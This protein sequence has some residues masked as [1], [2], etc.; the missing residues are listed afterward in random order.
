VGKVAVIT[1]AATGI[2]HATACLFVAHG[3]KVVIADVKDD[4]G[5]T[6][7]NELGRDCSKYIHCD[8]SKE[9]HVAAA[10]NLAVQ[11]FGKLDILYNNAGIPGELIPNL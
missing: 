11:S 6:L 9:S 2:G 7:A 1:G 4:A 8:V 3:A 10:V 5:Q